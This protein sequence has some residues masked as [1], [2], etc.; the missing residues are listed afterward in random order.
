MKKRTPLWIAIRV[1]LLIATLAM[2]ALAQSELVNKPYQQWTASDVEKMLS[3]S[4]W[5][6]TSTKGMGMFNDNVILKADS[7]TLRLRSAL[8]I[9]QGLLRLRQLNAKYDKKSDADKADFDSK[10][11]P[12]IDCPACADNYVIALSPTS[13]QGKGVPSILRTLP[14]D[15]M[16]LYIQ[17]ANEKGDKRELAHFSPPKTQFDEAV[18]FFPRLNDKG[19]PLITPANKKLIITFDSKIFGTDP[20]NNIKFEFDVSKMIVN[21]EVIF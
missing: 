15:S 6:Q 10:Q 14:P 16:K 21:G 4:P 20:V 7:V 5:A 13:R 11:K 12:L 19:E 17:I 1:V 8:P 9:R 18:F 2:T 3:D